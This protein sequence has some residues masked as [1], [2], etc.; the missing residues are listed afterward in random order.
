ML[1][2]DI[3]IYFICDLFCSP[4]K[5]K[6]SRSRDGISTSSLLI[7]DSIIR[8]DDGTPKNVSDSDNDDPF[9]NE[10]YDDGPD[11]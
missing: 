11:W 4:K 5:T 10:E 8:N 1:F 6:S 7:A 2:V 9:L 3:L